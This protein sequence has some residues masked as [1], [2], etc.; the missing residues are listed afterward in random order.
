LIYLTC[1]GHRERTDLKDL[2]DGQE[3]EGQ[4]V[5]QVS[6]VSMEQEEIR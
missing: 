6:E 5:C 2:M 3:K 1:R 4:K